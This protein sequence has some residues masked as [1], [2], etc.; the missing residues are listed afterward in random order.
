MLAPNKARVAAPWS[1][2]PQLQLLF[3]LLM[4]DKPVEAI[5]PFFF[6]TGFIRNGTI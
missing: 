3:L 4:L 5:H 2:G 6:A 1:V